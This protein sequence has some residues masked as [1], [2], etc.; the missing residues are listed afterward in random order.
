[1]SVL[2]EL[3]GLQKWYPQGDGVVKAL[4]GVDLTVEEG[5]FVTI[6][7][8]SG[9]GKSTLMNQL[10]CL[11]QP[12]G[13]RYRLE[14]E[15]VASLNEEQLSHIRRKTI[16]FVFQGFH[17]LPG[18]TALENVELPLYYQRIPALER[19]RMALEALDRVG[20]SHRAEHLPAQMSGG[21]QQRTAIARAIA[22]RPPLILADEPTGN[23][24]RQAGAQI[25]ELL[26]QLWQEGRTLILITHDPDIA[27]KAPR[28]VVIRDGRVVEEVRRD[29]MPQ[30]GLRA[31]NPE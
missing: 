2:M 20:L 28:T 22:P 5:E 27:A 4:D 7:G 19:R 3:R 11:D 17:L 29:Q 26:R 18:L 31:D 6:I 12:T 1:M 21:Q 9:S 14:G 16:G 8:P 30:S 24:D 10:G 13:G 15:D 25:M 23:L